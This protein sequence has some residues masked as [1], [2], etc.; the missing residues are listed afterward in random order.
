MTESWEEGGNC[1][2]DKTL[3]LCGVSQNL[4]FDKYIGLMSRRN[5]LYQVNVMV[6]YP[7]AV[8][9]DGDCLYNFYLFWERKIRQKLW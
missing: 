1:S 5:A 6:T 9:G 4:R 2:Y 8:S 7:C 3:D